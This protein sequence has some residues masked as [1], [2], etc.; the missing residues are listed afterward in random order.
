MNIITIAGN[1]TKDAEVRYLPNGDAVASF[2]IAD[3]QGKD[4]PA[5]FWNAS[6]FGKRGE[7]LA[8]YLTKGSPVTV[9]GSVTEREWTDKEGNKRKSMDVRVSEIALQGGRREAAH[10]APAPQQRQAAPQRQPH[11]PRQSVSDFSDM[12]DDIPFSDPMKRRAFALS[13]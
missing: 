3:N 10:E 5:I 2:G 11:Q 7:A 13:I 1:L 8:Q 4:K 12:A 6:L 9:A